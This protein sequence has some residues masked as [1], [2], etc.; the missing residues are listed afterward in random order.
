YRIWGYNPFLGLGCGATTPFLVWDVGLQPLLWFGIWGYNPFPDIGY[1]DTAPFLV[2]DVGIQA[3]LWFGI[4]GCIPLPD[5]FIQ[6]ALAKTFRPKA[7]CTGRNGGT[8]SHHHPSFPPSQKTKQNSIFPRRES[9]PGRLGENQE[10]SPLDHVGSADTATRRRACPLAAAGPAGRARAGPLRPRRSAGTKRGAERGPCRPQAAASPARA[11]P[12]PPAPSRSATPRNSPQTTAPPPAGRSSPPRRE[13]KAP[14][15]PGPPGQRARASPA[16]PSAACRGRTV[17]ISRLYGADTQRLP[18]ALL[19]AHAWRWVC[20]FSGTYRERGGSRRGGS[21]IPGRAGRK[22][23]RNAGTGGS[24]P[25]PCPAPAPRGG[26]MPRPCAADRDTWCSGVPLPSASPGR[27]PTPAR[28]LP[29]RCAGAALSAPVTAGVFGQRGIIACCAQIR[30]GRA[31]ARTPQPSPPICGGE[32]WTGCPFR[33][34]T[35]SANKRC[36]TGFPHSAPVLPPGTRIIYDRKFLLDRRN[37]PMAKTP[38]C[39]LPNIPGVTSPG[40]AGEEPKADS[41]SLNHQE[42][43]P[44]MGDDAQFEM[45]I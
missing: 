6:L 27:V 8:P 2:W 16:A 11:G 9:N 21:W 44:S 19:D 31:A 20:C 40:E 14:R 12:S 25:R 24:V 34:E 10:S 36:R 37:S 18:P 33:R 28:S 42:G 32:P 41:N 7:S 29:G 22:L 39:H 13:V 1:G 26:D 3:L 23:L 45:D 17:L 35:P 38:P 15:P 4:H 43:K 5:D 30:A